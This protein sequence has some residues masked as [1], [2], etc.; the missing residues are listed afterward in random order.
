[1]LRA[2]RDAEA[3]AQD[4]RNLAAIYYGLGEI[5]DGNAVLSDSLGRGNLVQLFAG[6][7]LLWLLLLV[8]LAAVHLVNEVASTAPLRAAVDGPLQWSIGKCT[9]CCSLPCWSPCS[10]SPCGARW[11]PA[12][13]WR[14]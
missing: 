2:G 1:M 12:T 3:Q 11:L 9:R 6:N 14:S 8:A 5:R 7:A 4:L 10:P 13:T